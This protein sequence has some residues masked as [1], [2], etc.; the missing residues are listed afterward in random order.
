MECILQKYTDGVLATIVNEIVY[1]LVIT[2]V[3]NGDFDPDTESPKPGKNRMNGRSASA[4]PGI[5]CSPYV[6]GE[7]FL[8]YM[9]CTGE[10]EERAARNLGLVYKVNLD[11]VILYRKGFPDKH[12]IELRD[13]KKYSRLLTYVRV[14]CRDDDNALVVTCNLHGPVLKVFGEWVGDVRTI[15]II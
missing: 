13:G 11:N 14:M 6:G 1:I 12:Y 9:W 10:T 4:Y 5:F 7:E 2:R 8:S 3:T 15:N